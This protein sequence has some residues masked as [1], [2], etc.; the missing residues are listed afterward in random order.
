M[1]D[2]WQFSLD[3]AK[4]WE[5]AANESIVPRTRK[6]L[7]RTAMVMSPDRGGVFDT[8]LRLVRFGLGGKA[9]DGRQF[10]SWVH[11]LD[12]IRSVY[13]LIGHEDVAGP[14]NLVAP[15]PLP[16]ADFMRAP[17][18][19]VGRPPRP[20]R[21]EV[22]AGGRHVSDADGVGTGAQEPA[23]RPGAVVG[24]RVWVPVPGLAGGG[25]R[26]VPAVL[27]TEL[28]N[29]RLTVEEKMAVEAAAARKVSGAS[30]ISCGPRRWRGQGSESW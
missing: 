18:P 24:V 1:P 6:V 19:G 27:R 16:Y 26:L 20:S 29:V 2:T 11:D 13:W 5:Q 9:G 7:M 12:F 8:L 30:E 10:V 25:G 23:G 4:A 17:A 22:D 15:G 21:H 3:V 14:V 28:V